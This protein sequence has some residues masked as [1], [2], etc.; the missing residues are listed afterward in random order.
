MTVMQAV[1]PLYPKGS[2][3]FTTWH[4][5]CSLECNCSHLIEWWETQQSIVEARGAYSSIIGPSVIIRCTLPVC[6]VSAASLRRSSHF[7]WP[8]CPTS[9]NHQENAVVR[10]SGSSFK[11][12]LCLLFNV[13]VL[14]IL[15][16]ILIKQ[17]GVFLL[18]MEQKCAETC[19]IT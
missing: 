13:L 12:K 11:V 5:V 10:G 15:W 6:Y 1:T 7:S 4:Q 9:A 16:R 18:L 8:S 17:V 3:L 14:D 19:N 2:W